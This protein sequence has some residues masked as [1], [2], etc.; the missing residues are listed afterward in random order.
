MDNASAL[1]DGL[2]SLEQQSKIQQSK[3]L[4]K[5]GAINE[6]SMLKTILSILKRYKHISDNKLSRLNKIDLRGWHAVI[7]CGVILHLK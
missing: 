6:T 1:V 4:K 5:F 3:R 7:N 2:I